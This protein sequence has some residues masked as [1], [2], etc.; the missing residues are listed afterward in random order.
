MKTMVWFAILVLA[1]T[2]AACTP[3]QQ[4]QTQSSAQQATQQT[5]KDASVAAKDATDA[6]LDVRIDAALAAE[7]GVNAFH[8]KPS[9]HGGVV[10]LSGTA[11]NATIDRTIL[12]TVRAVPGVKSVVNQIVVQR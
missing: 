11:P 9:A 6:A 10:T 5:R 3:Q 1:A 12:T 4:Q 2:F 8:V 7:A